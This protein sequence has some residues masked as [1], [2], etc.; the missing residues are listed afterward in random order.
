MNLNKLQTSIPINN[1]AAKVTNQKHCTN[2]TPTQAQTQTQLKENLTAKVKTLQSEIQKHPLTSPMRRVL[3]QEIAETCEELHKL[4]TLNK[5]PELGNYIL[6]VIK[7]TI[8]KFQWDRFVEEA[9]KRFE[10]ANKKSQSP[11]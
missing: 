11:T 6:E 5:T 10:E 1:T 9:N 4:K 2:E 3:G 7:E 8:P